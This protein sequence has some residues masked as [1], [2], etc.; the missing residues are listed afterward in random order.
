MR[1][2]LYPTPYRRP[3][4]PLVISFVAIG[5]RCV[6][7]ETTSSRIISLAPGHQSWPFK[8]TVPAL[9]YHQASS[10]P[11]GHKAL[12]ALH[13][14]GTTVSHQS[15]TYLNL[16]SHI[17]RK[18]LLFLLH[19]PARSPKKQ[20]SAT[21][22][23]LAT[24]NNTRCSCVPREFSQSQPAGNGILITKKQLCKDRNCQ[25]TTMTRAHREASQR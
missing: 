19:I 3:K 4:L 15:S 12:T 25:Q 7:Q 11:S 13:Q 17:Q 10:S 22:S 1:S 23:T 21:S 16:P 18:S 24:V 20:C 14:R 6:P 5:A 9:K 8:D 2:V